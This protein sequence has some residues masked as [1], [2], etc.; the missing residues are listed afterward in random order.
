[1]KQETKRIATR[2]YAYM[3]L[4]FVVGGFIADYIMGIHMAGLWH[5]PAFHGLDY[6]PLYLLGYPLAGIVMVQLYDTIA[7]TLTRRSGP[8]DTA[9]AALSIRYYVA[10]SSTLFI[11]FLGLM[12]TTI[13]NPDPTR[14]TVCYVC[15]AL[16]MSA[17][18]CLVTALRHHPT[19]LDAIYHNPRKSILAIGDSADCIC[20]HMS[21]YIPIM[22]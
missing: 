14:N 16:L 11:V 13:V 4:A 17:V 3:Y 19:M 5:Y 10:L 18:L 21:G 1:M 8:V 9:T 22:R 20:K 12:I 6:T 7:R 2:T 15:T